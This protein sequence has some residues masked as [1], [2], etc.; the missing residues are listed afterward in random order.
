MMMTHLPIGEY[1]WSG[2]NGVCDE[3]GTAVAGIAIASR[4]DTGIVGICPDCSLIPI[5]MLGD[6]NGALSADIA[7]FEHA[8]VN[9]AAVINNSWG[10]SQPI[11]AP[12]PLVDIIQRAQTETRGGKGS[13][14]VFAAGNDSRLSKAS[15]RI[16]V[17]CVSKFIDVQL[18]IPIRRDVDIAT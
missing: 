17:L 13:V 8:I 9:D 3:H 14:V 10:Y 11:A 15:C 16:D 4:N 6:G 7:S 5:K 12:Q 2:G 18:H 1:C